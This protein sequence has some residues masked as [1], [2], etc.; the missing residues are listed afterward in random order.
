MP[1]FPVAIPPGVFTNGTDLQSSGRWRDASLV[2]WANGA[3][4][5]VGGWDTRVTVTDEPIR[6]ALAWTDNSADPRLACGTWEACFAINEAG[7]VTDITPAGFTTGNVDAQNNSGFG[8]GFFGA[9]YF[10]TE[11]A[12]T[13]DLVEATTW[14]LDN[15]G[16]EL[17]ACSNADG[18]IYAWDLNVANNL[19]AVTNAPTGCLGAMVTE[20]RFL[21]ALGASNNPRNVSWSDREDRTDWTPAAT[22]EAGDIE[23]QTH[24]KIMQGIRT[25]GQALILTTVDAHTAT[26]IGPPFVYA[27]KRVG[28]SCGAVSRKAAAAIDGAVY[29]M[30][31]RGMFL[32]NGDTVTPLACEVS[33]YV[34]E[35]LNR[36][37]ASKVYAVA[38]NQWG[39]VW[40]FYPHADST[41]CDRYVVYNYRENHW[42]I[43]AIDRTAGVDQ[44]VFRWP[45]WF[46]SDGVAY[47]HEL[48]F[49]H[50]DVE[51]YAET[52]PLQLS[53]GDQIMHV[54]GMIPDE[55]TQGDVQATF[56]ARFYPNASETEFGPYTMTAP[57]SFRLSGR[58]VRMKVT[59]TGNANWRVGIMRLDVMPGGLR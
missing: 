23:L 11:R 32:F 34:F 47:N 1:L 3:M 44:G 9:G 38:N 41:E 49:T 21:F 8:G 25:R 46:A 48:G 22:N 40:W 52:G 24:G 43:G 57:T 59:G 50:G 7:T 4:Q 53:A 51:P 26:Y 28:T 13:D 20:E 27:F 29:W 6:G 17:I 37:Q 19:V 12:A 2:R 35:N 55:R 54:R 15:W 18:K 31:N 36:A 30:G 16:E 58:E 10:G 42:A 56:S 33:D 45:V 39:E 5:P 14:S